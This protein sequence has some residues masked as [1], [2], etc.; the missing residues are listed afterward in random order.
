[1][2]F[3]HGYKYPCHPGTYITCTQNGPCWYSTTNQQTPYNGGPALASYGGL[4]LMPR[5]MGGVF[6]SL[7]DWRAVNTIPES[8]ENASFR[9]SMIFYS[10]MTEG[11]NF[12]CNVIDR[13][14]RIAWHN[15]VAGETRKIGLFCYDYYQKRSEPCELCPVRRVFETARPCIME[16]HRL[17]RLPNGLLR[18]GEIRAYPALGMDGSVEAVMTIGFDITDR[19]LNFTRQQRQIKSLEKKLEKLTR[20]QSTPSVPNGKSSFGLTNRERQVLS[21]IASGFSN[22][23]ISDILILSRHTVKSHVTHIFNKLGVNDR[24]EAAFQAARSELI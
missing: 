11:I 4:N 23:E 2:R 15:K 5:P 10:A 19:K 16:R 12:H 22:A 8:L 14:Y 6:Y 18:W 21:L 7:K 17:E 24:T 13:D 1:L 9:M 20:R 3:A